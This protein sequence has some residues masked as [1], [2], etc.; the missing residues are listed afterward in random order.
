MVNTRE[1]HFLPY[2]SLEHLKNVKNGFVLFL[3]L[4]LTINVIK[5]QIYLVLQS[6]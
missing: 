6:I 4:K 5:S 1:K 2:K 3:G